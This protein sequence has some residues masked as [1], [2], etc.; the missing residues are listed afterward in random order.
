MDQKTRETLD[1]IRDSL[2]LAYFEVIAGRMAMIESAERV[3]RELS[4][5]NESDDAPVS[6]PFI[7]DRLSMGFHAKYTDGE[8]NGSALLSSYFGVDNFYEVLSKAMDVESDFSIP[9]S[10]YLLFFW[11]N[12]HSIAEFSEEK[13][14]AEEGE[15]Y[16]TDLSLEALLYAL[17]IFSKQHGSDGLVQ[18]LDLLW[19]DAWILNQSQYIELRKTI[20]L[21]RLIANSSGHEIKTFA[22]INPEAEITRDCA[23]GVYEHAVSL[24]RAANQTL[25]SARDSVRSYSEWL[26]VIFSLGPLFG[27][28]LHLLNDLINK[29]LVKDIEEAKKESTMCAEFSVD[30][31]MALQ[32]YCEQDGLLSSMYGFGS[33]LEGLKRKSRT[34]VLREQQF[35]SSGRITYPKFIFDKVKRI[36]SVSSNIEAEL[37]QLNSTV[38]KGLTPHLR[39]AFVTAQRADLD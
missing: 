15:V 29:G 30:S 32:V 23:D 3:L 1:D 14:I 38:F 28:C 34:D 17:N 39:N 21:N 5:S 26:R 12:T 10:R 22:D 35:L 24:A 25:C 36:V 6:A 9:T 13:Q 4:E 7:P 16:M 11:N 20:F 27:Y 19:S 8:R 31:I 33:V 37:R 18:Y 2:R